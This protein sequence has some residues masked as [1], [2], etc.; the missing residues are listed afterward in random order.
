M[1][2]IAPRPRPGFS[3][4]AFRSLPH[5]RGKPPAAAKAWPSFAPDPAPPAS[6]HD[7]PSTATLPKSAKPP[8]RISQSIAF[9]RR[10]E[11]TAPPPA[12][13]LPEQAFPSP[14][15]PPI[16]AAKSAPSNSYLVF[17]ADLPHELNL[18]DQTFVL[19]YLFFSYCQ[20]LT[21]YISHRTA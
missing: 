3:L 17:N 13:E 15:A 5:P 16:P 14:A 6:L 7:P 2:P 18:R 11:G 8:A 21:D 10:R 9:G 12:A 4:R 19:K 20:L 1:R